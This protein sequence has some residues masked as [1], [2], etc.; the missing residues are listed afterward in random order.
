[1]QTMEVTNGFWV[2]DGKKVIFSFI[3]KDDKSYFEPTFY[4][5]NPGMVNL[6]TAAIRYSYGKKSCTNPDKDNF[7]CKHI[8]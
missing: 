4:T 1:M 5:E 6:A 7:C 3:S 8:K 2:I